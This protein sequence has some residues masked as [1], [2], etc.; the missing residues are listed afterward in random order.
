MVK[1]GV[2]GASGYAGGE[3]V[4]YLLGHPDAKINFLGSDTYEG[5]HLGRAFSN[6]M[7]FDLPLCEKFSDDCLENADVFFLARGHG[8]AAGIAQK[9]LAAGKKVIDMSADFRFRDAEVFEQWY[10]TDHPSKELAKS[11]VYGLPEIKKQSIASAPLVANPGCYPTGAILALFPAVSAGLI[12]PAGIIID[13]KSG[14]SGAGRSKSDVG[15][16]FSEVDESLRPY[17]VGTHRHTPEIEQE[18]SEIAGRAIRVSFTP[19]LVPMIRGILTTAY[20]PLARDTT[21]S[22]ALHIYKELYSDSPFVTVLDEGEY[23]MTKSVSGSNFCHIGLKVD[24]RTGRLVMMS[25]IDNMGKGAAGQAV[26]NMNLMFGLAENTG[27]MRA[28]VYP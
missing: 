5:K 9:M 3:I 1:V 16:L 25:A 19:H 15:Y 13:S 27:L 4:R 24:S 18:I 7:G 8:W 20:A 23:P 14:V 17:G 6:L 28:G 21:T 10:K 26:Q 12:D 11:A 22:A 2:A